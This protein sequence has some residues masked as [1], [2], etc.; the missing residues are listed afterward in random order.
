MSTQTP[1]RNR[2]A[3]PTPRLGKF[4]TA[5]A[6]G[7]VFSAAIN[8]LMLSQSLYS[9]QVFTRAI[10]T[11]N[12]DTLVMLTL[13]TVLMLSIAA[14]LEA[15]RTRILNRAGTYLDVAY[16]PRLLAEHAEGGQRGRVAQQLLGD[17][18]ELRAFLGR[19]QF[20]G[21][22]DLPWFPLYAVA[23]YAIHPMLAV[24]MGVGTLALVA[25]AV[26][27]E[28]LTKR[29][30]EGARGAGARAVR[31]A[32][33]LS[34]RG[35]A[36]RGLRVQ[37][38][39]IDRWEEEALSANAQTGLA[40]DRAA[41]AASVTK[42]VRYLLQ[43]AATGV[44]AMLV[45][46]NH[47]SFGA[48]IA[49]TMLIGK[50]M[51]PID[52]VTGGWG[53]MLK[54]LAA[55]S[56]V[57]PQLRALSG[58]G[59]EH[60][61]VEIAGRVAV[62]NVLVLAGR[63][64]KPILRNVSFELEP[65]ELLCVFGPNRAGKTTLAK[66]LTGAQRPYAGSVRIDGIDASELRPADPMRAVGYVPQQAELLPGTVADNIA[67]FSGAD[68]AE[69][70]EAA[71]AFGLHE[72]IQALPQGYDTDVAEAMA[73]GQISGGTERLIALARAAFGAPR[74]LVL[75]E[76]VTNLDMPG[77]EA[78]RRFLA[79]ARERKATVIVLSHQSTF[80]EVADKVLVLKEGTTAAYGPRDQVVR[81][82]PRRPAVAAAAGAAE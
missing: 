66:L 75:D 29:H 3:V 81:Q 53:G 5:L 62:E 63:D 41:V 40:A 21:L 71:K 31:Y 10:P 18:S 57:M 7:F 37:G 58:A 26:L 74:L 82:Q 65:G 25:L 28:A 13:V 23:I 61:G 52:Q 11:G 78:V 39:V 16:R 59:R 45:M 30:Q 76:A 43:I 69:V 49:T 72:A 48:M 34:A 51:Q 56:R 14:A 42:W 38:G 8:V 50:A 15:L 19:P 64:Q 33:A 60:A 44:A 80:L 79:A 6:A 36:V 4:R 32:E 22:M 77:H 35:D 55:W 47:L 27:S 17:L 2:R 67:R 46:Q 12:F 54:S 70:V 9:L 73:V 20:A 24:V 1:P 68:R